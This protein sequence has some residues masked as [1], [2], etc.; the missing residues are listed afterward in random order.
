MTTIATT[1]GAAFALHPR[2][3]ADTVAVASFELSELRLMNDARYPW[4]ILVPRRADLQEFADLR[5]DEQPLLLAGIRRCCELL[6]ALHAPTRINIAM[7]GNLVP[8]LHAHV[9][10]RFADDEA[11]PRPVWGLGET[12]TYPADELA[13]RIARYRQ[14]L[15]L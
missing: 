6:K 11:W 10:A 12:R 1:A 8:Q 13:A 5:E 4:L 14:F 3:A 9:V 7:I 2:L 15:G